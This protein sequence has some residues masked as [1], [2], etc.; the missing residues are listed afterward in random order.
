MLICARC[1]DQ[2]SSMSPDAA[3]FHRLS[4]FFRRQWFIAG[5]KAATGILA[6]GSIMP[7]D[8]TTVGRQGR[9]YADISFPRARRRI[10]SEEAANANYAYSP[11]R[12]LHDKASFRARCQRTS[13]ILGHRQAADDGGGGEKWE[14]SPTFRAISDIDMPH[15]YLQQ[16][17]YRRDTL[18]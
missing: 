13:E 2:P 3:S 18:I 12:F 9:C 1:A 4:G 16:L 14:P 6:R 5:L 7:A 17:P 8:C 11:H 10:A 15:M